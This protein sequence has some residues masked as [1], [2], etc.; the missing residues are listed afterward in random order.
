MLEAFIAHL[1]AVVHWQDDVGVIEQPRGHGEHQ[2]VLQQ[3]QQGARHGAE[4]GI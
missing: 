3:L 4:A 1:G 2:Q